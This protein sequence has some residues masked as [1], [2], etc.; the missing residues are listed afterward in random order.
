MVL[1]DGVS[2]DLGRETVAS[3]RRDG[4]GAGGH[5]ADPTLLHASTCQCLQTAA[6]TSPMWSM[7]DCQIRVASPL[8]SI[9]P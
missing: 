9:V 1:Q 5:W 8:R 2:D 7:N 6:P 4:Y 3:E